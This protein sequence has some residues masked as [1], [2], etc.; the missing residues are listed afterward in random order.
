[1]SLLCSGV[2][3]VEYGKA[4]WLH[5]GLWQYLTSF[6]SIQ[7]ENFCH[8]FSLFCL[9]CND[10]MYDIAPGTKICLMLIRDLLTPDYAGW[11]Q[12]W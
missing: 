3:A 5:M 8:P 9:I 1:M 7:T 2:K 12:R 4:I 6:L 10:S 11:P